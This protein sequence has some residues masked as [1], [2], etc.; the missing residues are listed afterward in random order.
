MERQI[1]VT[2]DGSPSVFV[3][4][5]QEHYHSRFGARQESL[6][7][8]INAGLKTI[9][10]IPH[11]NVLEVGLGTGLN[12]L[13]TL[14]EMENSPGCIYYEALEPYPLTP[15]ECQELTKTN[16]SHPTWHEQSFQSIHFGNWDQ[17]I[18]LNK[19]FTLVKRQ[20]KL[21]NFVPSRGFH[22]VYYDAFAPA[23]Q[24]ELWTTSVF[25]KL[26]HAM[27]EGGLLVTYC[28]KGTVRRALETAGFQVEKL[29]GPAGKKEM[30]RAWKRSS[31]P[32]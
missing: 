28:S 2:A 16:R 26:F 1:V 10:H 4:E 27:G 29:P 19:N 7:V 20:L 17:Q 32:I 9:A 21:Q 13:L 23:V 15:G 8:Y 14:K 18:R 12:A 6:H 30:T 25:E 11:L 22:L 24:P 5:L 31:S 3:S